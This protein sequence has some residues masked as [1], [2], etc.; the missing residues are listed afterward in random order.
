MESTNELK[1][2]LISN[3]NEKFSVSLEVARM[4]ALVRNMLPDD[5]ADDEED[6]TCVPLPNVN[7]ATLSK[8]LAF[9]VHYLMEPMTPL[10]KVR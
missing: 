7:A 1:V 9:C 5:Y 6:E 3:D 4:S 10:V 8:V 2:V